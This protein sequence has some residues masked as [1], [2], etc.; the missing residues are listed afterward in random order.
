MIHALAKMYVQS[1]EREQ[2][3]PGAL[4]ADTFSSELRV[5]QC[6]LL[7]QCNLLNA[8]IPDRYDVSSIAS[9][10]RVRHASDNLLDST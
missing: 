10:V 3:E 5:S 8:F 1:G 2:H 9:R 6:S 4:P 7:S